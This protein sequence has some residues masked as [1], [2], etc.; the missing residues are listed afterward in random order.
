MKNIIEETI[1][2]LLKEKQKMEELAVYKTNIIN[3]IWD[4]RKK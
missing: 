3:K 1:K 4:I 2:L